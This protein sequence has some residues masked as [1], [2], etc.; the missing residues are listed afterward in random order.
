MF[1][2]RERAATVIS[3]AVNVSSLLSVLIKPYMPVVSKQ[4]QDQILL[5]EDC[6]VVPDSFVPFLKAGHKIGTPEPLFAKL[7]MS[8]A[9]EL[10]KRF[11]GKKAD[12]R[13][14]F[15]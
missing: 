8:L 4:M 2:F 12:V 15:T 14:V 6:N 3:L 13:I 9:E 10:K 7:E 1:L 5:P 11:A